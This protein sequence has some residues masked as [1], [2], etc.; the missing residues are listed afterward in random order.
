MRAR[1]N[2]RVEAPHYGNAPKELV[3]QHRAICA[4]MEALYDAGQGQSTAM[5]ELNKKAAE[6]ELRIIEYNSNCE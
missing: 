3:E 1:N 5:F 2:E 4:R 6:L